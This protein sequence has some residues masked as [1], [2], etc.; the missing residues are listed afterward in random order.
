MESKKFKKHDKS[1]NE[2]NDIID[3][4]LNEFIGPLIRTG[5]KQAIKRAPQILKHGKDLMGKSWFNIGV[6]TKRIIKNQNRKSKIND[7][8]D[9]IEITQDDAEIKALTAK[10]TV[11]LSQLEAAGRKSGVIA[12]QGYD[13]DGVEGDDF[14]IPYDTVILDLNQ[15]PRLSI[16]RS[17]GKEKIYKVPGNSRFNII[18]IKQTPDG[19]ILNVTNRD[20]PFDS[21]LVYTQTLK[22]GKTQR[23]ILQGI[24]RNYSGDAK[25]V[26]GKLI[27]FK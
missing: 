27:G 1:I 10:L 2:I 17:R 13:I 23:F 16:K 14:I 8:E 6:V 3:N 20:M 7:L 21:M 19:Y 5:V 4:Q 26:D 18:A 12:G 15:K 9:K 24:D 25:S 22:E 11:L